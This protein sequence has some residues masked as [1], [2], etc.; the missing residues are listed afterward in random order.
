MDAS[1]ERSILDEISTL[2][3]DSQEKVS[4]KQI[5]NNWTI[6]NEIAKNLIEKWLNANKTRSKEIS[7]E[8]LVNGY[9]SKG[10]LSFSV[11]S[12]D[13]KDKLK[14]KW[15]NFQSFIYSVQ[16]TSSRNLDLPDYEPIKV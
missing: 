5:S 16:L 1:T 13:I 8:F 14:K 15:K 3:F 10:V 12:G 7:I 6:K 2:V 4:L 11:V 9:N